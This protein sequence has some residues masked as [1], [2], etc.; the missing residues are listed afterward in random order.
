MLPL[1]VSP[2]VPDQEPGSEDSDRELSD[3]NISVEKQEENG[4]LLPNLHEN[5]V[6]C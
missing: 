4:V 6:D 3:L 1:Q 5:Y 2:T